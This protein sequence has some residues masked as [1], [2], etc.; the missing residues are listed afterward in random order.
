MTILATLW[1][2]RPG[3]ADAAKTYSSLVLFF[4]VFFSFSGVFLL[5]AFLKCLQR[6]FVHSVLGF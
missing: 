6:E 2:I 1:G 4:Y 5:K 3:T